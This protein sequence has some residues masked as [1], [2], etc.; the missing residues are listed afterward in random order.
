MKKTMMILTALFTAALLAASASAWDN[1]QGKQGR[2][3]KGMNSPRAQAWQSLSQE[4]K[5]QLKALRQQYI[6]QT[7]EQRTALRQ[8]KIEI[9]MLMQTSQPDRDRLVNL[10]ERVADLEKQLAVKRIDHQLAVKKIAP[11]LGCGGP[12]RGF[13]KKSHGMRHGKHGMAMQSGFVPQAGTVDTEN[14]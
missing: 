14:L 6:D 7:V 10:A 5:D 2:N 11:E 9:R 4:Q 12:G 13:G 1:S 3:G 8:N